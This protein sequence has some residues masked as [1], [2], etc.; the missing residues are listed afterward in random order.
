ML[1][2]GMDKKARRD[3][4]FA[5]FGGSEKHG[6]LRVRDADF[7]SLTSPK[8]HRVHEASE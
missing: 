7:E 1:R 2:K 3:L 8:A 4:T 5:A 6:W